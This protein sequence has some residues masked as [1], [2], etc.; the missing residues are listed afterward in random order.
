MKKKT[1]VVAVC[2][3]ALCALGFVACGGEKN[4]SVV[5][6]E[7]SSGTREAF[8]KAV[9]DGE[10]TLA[11]KV[12]GKNVSYVTKTAITQN[13]TSA[14]LATVAND[15]NAIGYVSLNS[16]GSEVKTLRVE[17]V[18]PSTESVLAGAYVIQRHFVIMTGTV[19][20]T[21]LAQDFMQ[22]LYS[23]KMEK[24]ATTAGCIFLSDGKMR[25]NEGENAIPVV[26]FT[27]QTSIPQGTIIVRGSTSMEKLINEAAKGYADVYG[28]DPTAI[29]D[30]QLEGSSVGK[31]MAKEDAKG[32]VIGLSSAEVS[33]AGIRSFNVC[34]DAVA[35][36]VHRENALENIT[37]KQLFDI[38]SG[39]VTKFSEIQQRRKK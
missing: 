20:L 23:A 35:V 24:H 28:A 27:P 5:V 15:V 7:D 3:A 18:T 19:R 34:L 33:E 4:I 10:H 9:T 31:K 17:G 14:V 12:D 22:Y 26:E 16:V 21:P 38:F 6:R 29:F 36:I 8:D 39:K 25:A 11:E 1:K 13:K 37:R 2:T 30:I 32:N